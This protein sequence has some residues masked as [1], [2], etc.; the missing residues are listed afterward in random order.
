MADSVQRFAA[1]FPAEYDWLFSN[2]LAGVDFADSLLRGIARYGNL[3]PRQLAA[4]QRNLPM[5][6]FTPDDHAERAAMAAS[7][8]IAI[9]IE[10]RQPLLD[11]A[12]AA[13]Q[14]ADNRAGWTP[15]A[16]ITVDLDRVRT[17]MDAAATS[18]LRK[19]RLT[20]GNV[21]FKLSGARFHNGGAGM[22][23]CYFKR[24]V[25]PGSQFEYCGFVDRA[26]DWHLGSSFGSV[27]EHAAALDAFRLA[28]RDPQAAARTHGQDT[29][30]CACCRRLLTDPVSVMANIGPICERRFGWSR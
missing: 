8:P 21:E 7:V 26:N 18:G 2:R 6:S 1:T 23:L 13:A 5:I 9:D 12:M 29:G 3:T 27:P 19:V 20:L 14:T 24:S 11:A 30:H 15:P 28:G 10:T 22:I 16:P 25:M 17:A 4:V